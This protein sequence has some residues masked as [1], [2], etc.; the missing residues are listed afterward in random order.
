[1]TVKTCR[2]SKSESSPSGL[3]LETCLLPSLRFGRQ[4][5]VLHPSLGGHRRGLRCSNRGLVSVAFG[6]SELRTTESARGAF[7][8]GVFGKVGSDPD[9]SGFFGIRERQGECRAAL[10]PREHTQQLFEARHIAAGPWSRS[11][12]CLFGRALKEASASARELSK[13]RP[14]RRPNQLLRWR[15]RSRRR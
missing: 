9:S 5:P 7:G 13:V 3:V 10:G 6:P 1:M 11:A 4:R 14:A 15:A 12:R 8:C 2:L